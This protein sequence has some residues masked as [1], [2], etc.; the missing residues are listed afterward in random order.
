MLAQT[1]NF[2]ILWPLFGG[3][4]IDLNLEDL[5]EILVDKT[6]IGASGETYLINS[7]LYPITPLLFVEYAEFEWKVDT[8]NSNH[9]FENHD[10]LNHNK[11]RIFEGYRGKTVLGTHIYIPEMNWCLLAE[12]DDSEALGPQRRIFLKVSITIILIIV[13]L[14]TLVGLH[15]G[16]VIEKKTGKGKK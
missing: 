5:N 6:G 11:A 10:P 16:R 4:I 9:C 3:I 14:V 1:T 2:N 15:V 13:I 8:S 12:V 7:E